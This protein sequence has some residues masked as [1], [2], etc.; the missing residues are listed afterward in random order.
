MENKTLKYFSENKNFT[1]TQ[2]KKQTKKENVLKVV[3]GQ[4]VLNV[5]TPSANDEEIV[6]SYTYMKNKCGKNRWNKEQ[7][8]VFYK[9]LECCG[10]D[11]SM[12]NLLFPDR[13][14]NNLK[15]KYKKE[16]KVNRH[17][18]EDILNNFKGNSIKR[19]ENLKKAL[20]IKS[21]NKQ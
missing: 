14:R 15:D 11:F 19:F 17:R 1:K 4:I 5:D 6:T 13:T 10:L 3:D 21:N 20:N 8:F 2:Q 9:A 16:L 18:I 7:N 12:M